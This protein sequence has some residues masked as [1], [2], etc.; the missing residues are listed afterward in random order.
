MK[1]NTQRNS[2]ISYAGGVRASWSIIV[3][4]K[5]NSYGDR[6]IAAERRNWV[7]SHEAEPK[8]SQ[9][10]INAFFELPFVDG[11]ALFCVTHAHGNN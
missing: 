1:T 9:R 6:I 4:R 10:E 2:P 11:F 5:I 8:K 7:G 3:A